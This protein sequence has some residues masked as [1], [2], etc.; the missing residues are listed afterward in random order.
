MKH[1]R[2]KEPVRRPKARSR[3]YGQRY[4]IAGIVL[5]FLSL[6]CLWAIFFAPEGGGAVNAWLRAACSF[7]AGGRLAFLPLFYLFGLG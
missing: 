6:A 2:A 5:V 7:L 4:E 3:R 1:G